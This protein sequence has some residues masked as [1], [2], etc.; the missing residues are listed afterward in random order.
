VNRAAVPVIRLYDLRHTVATLLLATDVNG[1]VVSERLGRESIDITL[2]HHAQSL[3]SMQPRASRRFSAIG[4]LV[5]H[6]RGEMAGCKRRD[7]LVFHMLG[8]VVERYT[9]GT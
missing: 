7:V 6:G 2:K 5:S 3:P 9:Q 4:P 1:K 8:R